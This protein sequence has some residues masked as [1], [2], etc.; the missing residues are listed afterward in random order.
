MDS[1][2]PPQEPYR[3]WVELPRDV[4]ASILWKLGAIEILTSA[5]LVCSTWRSICKDP[6]MWRSIDMH[7]LGDLWDMDYDLGRMCRHAVDRSSGGLVDVNIEYFGTDDLLQYIADR[8]SHLKRLRLVCC[9]SISDEGLSEVAT[10]FPLLEELDISYC[11]LSKQALEVVGRCC[12]LLKSFKLNNQGCRNPH[13]ECNEE[14]L[15][16]A[17][18]M[19]HLRYLQIFGNKLTNEGLQ[20]ILDG[21]PHLESLDLRQCFNVNMDGHLGKRCIERI[22]DLRHPY[23]PTDDYPFDAEIADVGSSEEDYPSGFSEIDFL[24]DDDD[25]Y[26]FSGGSDMSDFEHLYFD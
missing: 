5:Q 18:H 2:S 9:Y 10:K 26:E 6:S 20:A 13:I 3:N 22:K 16:I 11:S 23:D 12:P 25:Y 7:N 4:T 19:P 14:A 21:C 24:S 1:L 8:S 15:A 17:E